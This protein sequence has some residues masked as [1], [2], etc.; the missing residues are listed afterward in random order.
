V[1]LLSKGLGLAGNLIK[2]N[3]PNIA[4]AIPGVGTVLGV[5]ATAGSILSTI[6]GSGAKTSGGTIPTLPPRPVGDVQT[7]FA[8][9]G[10]PV[11]IGGGTRNVVAQTFAAWG[12]NPQDWG[13]QIDYWAR[14]IDTGAATLANVEADLP[15]AGG[16]RPAPGTAVATMGIA[17]A[18]VPSWGNLATRAAPIIGRA[19]AR[20]GS[21]V[22]IG[23]GLLGLYDAA[24]NLMATKKRSRRMNVLNPKALARANRRVVGFR[25]VAVRSLK[26]YG[27]TVSTTRKAKATKGKRRR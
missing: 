1:S 22:A 13:P 19:A 26:Q 4:R 2:K 15:S 5:A 20:V 24:G 10:A 3:L 11:S 23:G 27:Y 6:R 8:P 17:G 14:S 21:W 18:G 12:L 16:R 9:G 25:D 7:I